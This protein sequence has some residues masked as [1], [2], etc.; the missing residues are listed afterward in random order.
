M[1]YYF[2]GRNELLVSLRSVYDFVH[3]SPVS[4]FVQQVFSL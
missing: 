1:K 3:S 4:D 2:R